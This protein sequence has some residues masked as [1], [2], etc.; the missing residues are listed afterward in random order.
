MQKQTTLDDDDFVRLVC[1]RYRCGTLGLETTQGEDPVWTVTDGVGRLSEKEDITWGQAM[2]TALEKKE[3]EWTQRERCMVLQWMDRRESMLKKIIN[4]SDTAARVNTQRPLQRILCW[5]HSAEERIRK[6]EVGKSWRNSGTLKWSEMKSGRPVRR[7]DDTWLVEKG[8]WTYEGEWR[9]RG[10]SRELTETFSSDETDIGDPDRRKNALLW[11]T[12]RENT[13]REILKEEAR[14]PT[15]QGKGERV[16]LGSKRTRGCSSNSALI[17]KDKCTANCC[18]CIEWAL[19]YR[20]TEPEGE[21]IVFRWYDLIFGLLGI[22]LYISDVGTDVGLAHSHYQ[23]GDFVF[24]AVT[25][26]FVLVSY[27]FSCV[28]TL[29]LH[30][31]NDH[32]RGWLWFPVLLCIVFNMGPCVT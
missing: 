4:T 21:K 9:L 22:A 20:Q 15:S 23:S 28:V 3:E 32:F 31:R 24:F 5:I 13:V 27:V 8:W 12:M 30:Y 16:E 18:C 7:N 10:E 14:S 19:F 29:I 1:D 11:V 2:T 17:S 6:L 26:S 25:L